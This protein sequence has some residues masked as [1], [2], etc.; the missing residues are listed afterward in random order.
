L[1]SSKLELIADLCLLQKSKQMPRK[2]VKDLDAE[3]ELLEIA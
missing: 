2:T 3:L 1:S